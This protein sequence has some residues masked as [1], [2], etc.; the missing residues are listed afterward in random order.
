M[1]RGSLN[2]DGIE[3]DHVAVIVGELSMVVIVAPGMVRLE[4]PMNC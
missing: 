4:V 1:K 2:G 3:P